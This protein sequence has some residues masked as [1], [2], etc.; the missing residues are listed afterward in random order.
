[1][2]I[3]PLRLLAV[4]FIVS[5]DSCKQHAVCCLSADGTVF[6]TTVTGADPECPEGTLISSEEVDLDDERASGSATEDGV[7]GDI[8]CEEGEERTLRSLLT[9]VE[10]N[11]V[12]L[13]AEA[14]EGEEEPPPVGG[15]TC[16]CDDAGVTF[17]VVSG[18][19]GPQ[20]DDA[21]EAS[22]C[23]SHVEFNLSQDPATH[24]L[25]SGDQIGFDG[26]TVEVRC[27]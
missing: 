27:P 13:A 18:C 25:S 17:S 5:C 19:E 2:R 12:A 16:R 23:R 7:C 9:C 8:C 6:A 26:C 24:A 1:M 11:G 14:C 22:F 4:L 20:F 15:G 10:R 21:T 3:K